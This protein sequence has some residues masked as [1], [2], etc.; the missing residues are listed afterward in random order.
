[1]EPWGRCKR[2]SPAEASSLHSGRRRVSKTSAAVGWSY[3]VPAMEVVN[4]HHPLL[5]GNRASVPGSQVVLLLQLGPLSFPV[6][7][8][9]SLASAQAS[10]LKTKIQFKTKTLLKIKIK[11]KLKTR[12]KIKTKLK[13]C[14]SSVSRPCNPPA[15]QSCMV[16]PNQATR[17]AINLSAIFDYS[18]AKFKIL[19]LHLA[20]ATSQPLVRETLT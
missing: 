10:P 1:M 3:K 9:S 17:P 11:L 8:N 14:G 7:F 4:R 20:S 12:I 16:R 15:A 19:R 6:L 2:I 18:L 5:P 13:S